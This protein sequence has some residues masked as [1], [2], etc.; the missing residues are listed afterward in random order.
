[1]SFTS[2]CPDCGAKLLLLDR[3]AGRPA[4]CPDCGKTHVAGMLSSFLATH[5]EKTPEKPKPGEKSP[6]RAVQVVDDRDLYRARSYKWPVAAAIL[7]ALVLVAGVAIAIHYEVIHFGKIKENP[8]RVAPTQGETA[9]S[10]PSSPG[11]S[12]PVKILR[13]SATE[14]W[15]QVQ[16]DPDGSRTRFAKVQVTGTA[17]P[18]PGATQQKL[19]G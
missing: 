15:R 17:L 8:M 19:R 11:A 6:G 5:S 3:N 10:S 1:M 18:T 13:L 16:Q 9:A 2:I 7:F 14:F 4:T 12:E